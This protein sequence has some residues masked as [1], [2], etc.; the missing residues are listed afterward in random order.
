MPFVGFT[1]L[2][3]FVAMTA[4]EFYDWCHRDENRDRN[5]EVDAGV[6]VQVPSTEMLESIVCGNVSWILRNYSRASRTGY[7][8]S[9]N[10]GLILE[11]KPDTVFGPDIALFLGKRRST[12]LIV[13]TRSI[14]RLSRSRYGRR[15]II[16]IG[17]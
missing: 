13:D 5:Y 7:V 8:C 11:R 15:K 14:C 16:G 1:D 3:R 12:S 6:V 10:V 4:E 17:C 2:Q 9:N